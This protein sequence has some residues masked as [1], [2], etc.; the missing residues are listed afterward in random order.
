[1]ALGVAATAAAVPVRRLLEAGVPVAL[2]ADDPLLFGG[3]L[4]VQYELARRELG[5]DDAALADLAR[6]SVHAS[7]A[8]PEVRRSALAGIDEWLAA[9]PPPLA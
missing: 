6:C 4:A 9:P 8:P 3:R 1:V 5:L 7:S 2:G